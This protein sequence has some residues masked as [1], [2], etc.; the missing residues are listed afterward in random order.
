MNSEQL[1]SLFRGIQGKI[2]SALQAEEKDAEFSAD[3]WTSTLGAGCS[4][5][6]RDGAVYESAGV[7]FSMVSGASLPAAATAKRPQFVGM[8]YQAMGVSVVVHPRNPH[9]PTSHAN[10][11]IFMVTDADG[12]QH[13]WLGGGF[14]LTPIHLYDAD[15]QHFHRT[16]AAALAP[17][18][19]E[20]YP[21]FKQIADDY[22]YLP[23]RDEYR[24]IGGIFYDDLDSWDMTTNA[25][26]IEAIAAAYVQAYVP[27]VARRKHQV[28]LEQERQ[29]QL[30]R[31]TRYAEFN[32][33]VDRGTIF[34]L[35]SKGRTQSILMSM[36][37]LASWHYDD[38]PA[39]TP[40]QRALVAAVK[41]P[42]DWL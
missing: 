3:N 4:C 21:R 28:W 36:P 33:L 20:L 40:A 25:R 9:V 14:D 30:Y 16:A 15:A 18:G 2:I 23:H 41:R 24:G 8:P 13:C 12:R 31:R 32:L 39:E 27:I 10:V 1:E 7:N 17:F 37:P 22:F 5:V 42:Q 35:Q 34:G 38:L 19:D 26:F 11:R 6:L 29:F